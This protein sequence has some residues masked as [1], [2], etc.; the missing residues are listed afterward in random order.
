M[1]PKIICLSLAMLI[2]GA[3]TGKVMAQTPSVFTYKLG[4]YEVITLAEAEGM[5][6]KNILIGATPEMLA[7]YAPDGNIPNGTNAYLIRSG[8]RNVLVDAGFGRKLFS[9]LDSLRVS[10]DKIDGVLLTHCHGDHI[11]GL[12]KDGKAA[13]PNAHLY[14]DQ[15]EYDYWTKSAPNDQTKAVF[16][17]YEGRI[18]KFVSPKVGEKAKAIVPGVSAIAAYG[19]T[20]GHVAFLVQSGRDRMLIWG[21]LTHAMAIQMPYP[22]VA[23][24]Y[25]VNPADA[26]KSRKE[27]LEYVANNNIPIAGMHVK[28]PG[29]GKVK[30]DGQ[31]GYVLTPIYPFLDTALSPSDRA[32]DIVSRLTLEEKVPQMLNKAP[33]IDRLGIPAYDWWNEC[34]HGVARTPEYKV[35]VYPQ[36]IGMAAGWDVE[37][38]KLMGDYTSTEGRAIYNTAS[39]KGDRRIYRG[40]TYWTP[41]INIFRD[42]RWGRGQETYGEDPYLTA[43]I[44]KNFVAGLQGSDKTMLKA[45]AC[46]K[47]YAV[48]SGP[49][50]SRHVFDATASAYDLWDTYLPAFKELVVDASVAGV[51]CAYNA[52]ESQPCCGSD[53][54][55]IDILR[56]DWGFTGYVTSDCGAIDD[57]YRNHKTHPDAAAA[58]ADAVIHG[59]DVDCGQSTYKALVKAVADGII[60]EEQ[61]DISL[62]RLFEIRY[63]LGV[64]DPAGLQPYSNI[65]S[66]YLEAKEH[67]A[68]ALKM[69]KQS[70]VL[71]KND[72]LLPLKKNGVKKIAVVGPNADNTTVQLGNYN[73]FPTRIISLLDGLKDKFPTGVNIVYEKGCDYVVQPDTLPAISATVEKVKDADVIIFAGGISPRLEGEEMRVNVPGFTG[74]DRTS[75]LLPQLQTDM[76]KALKA[77]G[78]PVIF[79]MMTGSAIATPW[80][81]A[82]VNAILNAWYGGESIG[83]ALADILFG[84]YNPS[85]HLP[86]TFYAD[87][88][89]L[90]DFNEYDMAGR[91]YKYFKGKPLYPFGFGLSYTRF[92]YEWTKKPAKEY[93]SGDI[94]QCE[95][96][97]RNTGS[98]DGD[99]VPQIYIKYPGASRQLPLKELRAFERTA[100]SKGGTYT[101]KVSIPVERLAKW[102]DSKAALSVPAG[103][104]SIYAGADS[105]DEATSATFTIKQQ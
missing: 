48:H 103:V 51:M 99:A 67:K 10:P 33:A 65:D 79:V 87:D 52:F 29:M 40:L 75:I 94:I 47:H 61:I 57:F 53:K 55:M 66:T 42:P 16:A 8:G 9:N 49:E 24:T 3:I 76:M 13:F 7:K 22:Q 88:A 14:L 95:V 41:N 2:A 5:G 12:L 69:A 30:S 4:Q 78:K 81:S 100:I 91:T 56:K 83:T 62:R 17:A 89:D 27:I 80:E 44:G 39:A 11:G 60:R 32:K 58:A 105:G 54:L 97:V 98:V 37:A 20:P 96:K 19:H 93:K 43:S 104:Y 45:A 84:D 102:D 23:V 25:D 6:N 59:T 64:L 86:L 63:R 82:N 92:A 70:V 36:A 28:F 18:H 50:S 68:L 101:M 74:G 90:P 71:L 21:D 73:G 72:G 46:A 1:N 77:T 85:G 35:T 34:L 26:I 38:M 15:V 31:S